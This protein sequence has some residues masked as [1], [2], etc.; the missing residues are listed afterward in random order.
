LG[1]IAGMQ[2]PKIT[3]PDIDEDLDR[4]FRELGL[5]APMSASAARLIAA[6]HLAREV[7][8]GRLDSVRGASVITELFSWDDQSAAAQI[9]RI[10]SDLIEWVR[11]DSPEEAAAKANVV[12]ACRDFLM[13][14]G[15]PTRK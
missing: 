15:E 2:N 11:R 13:A 12:T 1:I 14:N 4:A 8:D 6:C 7:I 9:V 5:E 3:H 10:H